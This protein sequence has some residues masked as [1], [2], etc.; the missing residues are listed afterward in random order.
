MSVVTTGSDGWRNS[1]TPDRMAASDLVPM[2][3]LYIECE[4]RFAGQVGV[5][6]V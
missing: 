5:V 6:P 4:A 1:A 2:G 3:L